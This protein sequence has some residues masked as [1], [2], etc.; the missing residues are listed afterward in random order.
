MPLTCHD[1]SIREHELCQLTNKVMELLNTRAYD[2][3]WFK[4]HVSPEV[5]VNYNGEALTC[6]LQDAMSHYQ[7]DAA[8]SP[9]FQCEVELMTALSNDFRR[10]DAVILTE[11]MR[12]F[13]RHEVWAGKQR[14]AQILWNWTRKA[15]IW[16]LQSVIMMF[17][18]CEY[19]E[20]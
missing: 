16:K 13:D 2:D 8:I 7:E 18:T 19:L 12:N 15:E 20:S 10:T 4:I 5:R 1:P 11:R 17:G 14:S 6:G 3:P 9:N